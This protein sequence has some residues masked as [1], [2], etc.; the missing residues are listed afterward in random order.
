MM[1]LLLV[2][3][4]ITNYRSTHVL[5]SKQNYPQYFTLPLE[6]KEDII[7]VSALLIYL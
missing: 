3:F 1:Q 5:L 2:I 4:N 6:E 7:D